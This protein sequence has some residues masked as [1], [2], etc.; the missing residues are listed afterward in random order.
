M[1]FISLASFEIVELVVRR[2]SKE[3]TLHKFLRLDLLLREGKVE[4]SF[5]LPV[6]FSPGLRPSDRC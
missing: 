1:Q 6:P 5:P 2:R 3:M 4:L